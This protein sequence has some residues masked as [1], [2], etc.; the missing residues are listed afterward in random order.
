MVMLSDIKR[1]A[2]D[3]ARRFDPDKI[4]LFGSHASGAQGETSD[5]D[6]LIVMDFQGPA[7]DQSS[8]I[9]SALRPAFPVD[10][11]VRTPAEVA[12]RYAQFDPLIREAIDK[13]QVLHERDRARVAG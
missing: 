13:G 8:A 9:W 11:I 12:R 7:V 10:L 3:I 1:L 2:A 5:V 4:V 6:L